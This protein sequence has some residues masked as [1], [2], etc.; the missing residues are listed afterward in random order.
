MLGHRQLK[1]GLERA[2]SRRQGGSPAER[3]RREAARLD[4]GEHTPTLSV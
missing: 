2:R 1:A 3:G 4:A